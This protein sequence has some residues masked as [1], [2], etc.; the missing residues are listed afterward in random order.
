MQN[1]YMWDMRIAVADAHL[2]DLNKFMEFI[3]GFSD[4]FM[5]VSD[6]K[7]FVTVDIRSTP[8]D[9][10]TTELQTSLIETVQR[11]SWAVNEFSL[12]RKTT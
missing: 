11:I 5:S 9:T 1:I 2:Y 3:D 8:E 6:G 12:E 7:I 4:L 10:G